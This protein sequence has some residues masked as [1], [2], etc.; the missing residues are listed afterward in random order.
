MGAA[1]IAVRLTGNLLSATVHEHCDFSAA[2]ELLRSCKKHMLDGKVARIEILLDEVTKCN[3]CIIGAALLL[4]DA[5]NGNFEIR[6]KNSSAEVHS[7]FESGLLK[8]YFDNSTSHDHS[9]IVCSK[10]FQT[11]CQTPGPHC[12]RNSSNFS[13]MTADFRRALP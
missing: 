12:L 13:R 7:L 3:S 9:R 5:M 8:R 4:S 11:N 6:V 2:R 10:C 1:V